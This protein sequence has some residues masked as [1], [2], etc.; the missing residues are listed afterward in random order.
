MIRLAVPDIQDDDIARMVEVV[1]SGQ[2][3]QGKVVEEFEA[4]LAAFSG[5]EHCVVVS[6]GTSA[7]HL[8]LLALDVGC[9]DK[10]IVPAF[11][12]PA[13]ANAVELV[14]ASVVLCDV[15]PQSYVVT[16]DAIQTLLDSDLGRDVK[17]IMLVHEFGFPVDVKQISEIAE[18]RGIKVIEDAAC[19]LGTVASGYHPGYYSDVA[20]FSF[21]PRK[22]ITTGE[23][24]AMLSRDE[25]LVKLARRLRNHGTQPQGSRMDFTEAGLN[26]RL[27]NF[28]AALGVGQVARFS[29]ELSIRKQMVDLYCELLG[30]KPAVVLPQ[31][32]DGHSWQS[33]MVVL[34][35]DLR[36]RVKKIM[37]ERGVEVNLGAHALNCLTY[38]QQTYALDAL[39]CPVSTKLYSD[40]LVLPLHGR[41]SMNDVRDVAQKLLDCIVECD[42]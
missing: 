14:G 33:F 24:G 34:R 20:C 40:G 5:I 15:D 29:E 9:G 11:T 7:L 3:V 37:L 1:R 27:T 16:P 32:K 39:S 22:A 21:H 25:G 36:E 30:G 35:P 4:A 2:L 23:G 17:A 10:V 19:A 12:Y 26:Y 28:Q 18:K 31:R 8:A 38:F 13:T 6:S 41:M 42:G